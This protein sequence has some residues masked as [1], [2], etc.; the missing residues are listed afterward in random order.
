MNVTVEEFLSSLQLETMVEIF[1]KEHITMDVLVEMTNEDL[2][3][4]GVDAFGHRHKILR[5]IK[6]LTTCAEEEIGS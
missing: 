4:V 1:Q 3:S 6:E 2:Q 5:K